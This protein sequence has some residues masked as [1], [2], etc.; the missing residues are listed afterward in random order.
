MT[1]YNSSLQKAI[2]NLRARLPKTDPEVAH[3]PTIKDYGNCIPG[4][5]I[6]HGIGFVGK[7]D[8]M[9]AE[10]CPNKPISLALTGLPESDWNADWN[11]LI[12]TDAVRMMTKAIE[13]TLERGSGLLYFHGGYGIGKT[14]CLKAA[15]I[16]AVKKRYQATY[17]RHSQMINHL[18]ASNDAR[19]KGL[20]TYEEL[21]T[22]YS[23]VK[24]LAI[25]EL[26]RSRETEFAAIS[27]SDILDA[28]YEGAIAGN[29]ITIIASNYAPEESL[30]PYQEDRIRDG[31]CQVVALEGVSM[32]AKIT[33][34][35]S[36]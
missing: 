29:L 31:R 1:K 12:Q 13:A 23:Q 33:H 7:P 9:K 22:N 36:N 17:V 5:P 18:R 6:C 4:C 10:V 35:I 8:S 11:H 21:L 14:V 20:G 24:F 34:T 27:F 19:N 2:D 3:E 30:E 28:R 15:T 25:D 16:L 32:R 26:G